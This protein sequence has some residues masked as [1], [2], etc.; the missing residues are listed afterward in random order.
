MRLRDFW[1]FLPRDGRSELSLSCFEES[2]ATWLAEWNPPGLAWSD[3]KLHLE[4][5]TALVVFDGVDEVPVSKD[6]GPGIWYPRS[7]LIL[8]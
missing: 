8:A 1:P 7:L 3:L 5:G 6:E 2:L 4:Q